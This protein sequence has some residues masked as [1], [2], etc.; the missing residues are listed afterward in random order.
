MKYCECDIA[1]TLDE[2][3]VLCHDVNFKRLALFDD[4]QSSREIGELTYR[5]LIALP[6]KSGERPPKLVDALQSAADIGGGA[7]MV[8]EIKT[9][10]AGAGRALCGLLA[11]EPALIQS[12]GVVMSFDLCILHQFA[13]EWLAVEEERKNSGTYI[14]REFQILLLTV[15]DPVEEAPYL[16]INMADEHLSLKLDGTSHY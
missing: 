4:G 8:I 3:L 11:N 13:K 1:L 12:V 5:E 7:Q 14:Q 9:G 2:H 16:H 6:L 10:N 15:C